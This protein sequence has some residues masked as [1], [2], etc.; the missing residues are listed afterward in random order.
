MEWN[1]LTNCGSN[2][3][4]GSGVEQY[5]LIF[6]VIK[7]VVNCIHRSLEWKR[8]PYISTIFCDLWLINSDKS[9]QAKCIY[10]S[11]N[12]DSP[13]WII[14]KRRFS[15]YSLHQQMHATLE[16]VKIPGCEC[17]G[18]STVWILWNFHWVEAVAAQYVYKYMYI[19][20]LMKKFMQSILLW[21]VDWI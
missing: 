7:T 5:Q 14:Y 18:I 11:V 19:L 4:S 15:R 12:G 21:T 6:C 16:V 2:C 10:E 1:Q 8:K 20:M 9:D 17:C 3:G 13:A